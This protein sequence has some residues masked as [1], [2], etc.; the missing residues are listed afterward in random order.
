[1]YI[2]VVIKNDKIDWLWLNLL[3]SSG[4]AACPLSQPRALLCIV[5]LT[6]GPRLTK[7]PICRTWPS[8]C[9]GKWELLRIFHREEML[10]LPLTGH[11]P[12]LVQW[13]STTMRL[14]GHAVQHVPGRGEHLKYLVKNTVTT[15][16]AK[17][18]KLKSLQQMPSKHQFCSRHCVRHWREDMVL[19]FTKPKGAWDQWLYKSVFGDRKF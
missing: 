17:F 15:K 13:P 14:L 7:K 2:C 4:Q 5:V 12:E 6:P 9:G 19:S 10:R 3:T 18:C 16:L 11:W 8:S 1:M